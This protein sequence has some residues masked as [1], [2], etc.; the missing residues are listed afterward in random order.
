MF[1]ANVLTALFSVD[2]LYKVEFKK[3]AFEKLV[4]SSYY[5]DTVRA[6]VASRVE[7]DSNHFRDLVDGKGQGVVILLHSKSFSV[8][9][10][11]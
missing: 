4:M 1:L 11:V 6:M 2:K 5:K 9:H 10:Y 3:K 7:E 8:H